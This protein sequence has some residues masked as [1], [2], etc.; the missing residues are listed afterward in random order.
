M[1]LQLRQADK[2]AARLFPWTKQYGPGLGSIGLGFCRKLM[3]NYYESWTPNNCWTF[4][5]TGGDGVHFSLLERDGR[6]RDDSP[7]VVTQPAGFRSCIVGE[8]LYDFLCFGVNPIFR[9]FEIIGPEW[10]PTKAWGKLFAPR[11]EEQE[12]LGFLIDRFRLKP[13]ADKK[14]FR[15]LQETFLMELDL[16]PLA[17]DFLFLPPYLKK[18]VT[19]S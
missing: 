12:V 3:P 2:D 14:R 19:T 8:S 4:A 16:P 7:V 9:A 13:W 1:L 10:E 6:I 5:G 15:R 17:K 11:Q 18:K